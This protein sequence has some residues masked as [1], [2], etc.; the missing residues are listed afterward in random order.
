MKLNCQQQKLVEQWL[1][2]VSHV[3]GKMWRPGEDVEQMYSAGCLALCK[4]AFWYRDGRGA[5]FKT[6]AYRSIRNEILQNRLINSY[7]TLV[8]PPHQNSEGVAARKKVVARDLFRDADG[9]CQQS[10]VQQDDTATVAMRLDLEQAI[11]KLTPLQ[12]KYIR[13]RYFEGWKQREI[14]EFLGVSR[15]AVSMGSLHALKLLREIMEE[16]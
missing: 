13:L 5:T 6:Y 3:I 7:A 8:Y 16:S 10:F 12:S 11:D 4:A 15:G 1:P 14:A 2:L 9:V